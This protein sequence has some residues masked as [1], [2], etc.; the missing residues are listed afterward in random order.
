MNKPAN[1]I[2][3]QSLLNNYK[4]KQWTHLMNYVKN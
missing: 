4:C 2:V 1:T 3:I